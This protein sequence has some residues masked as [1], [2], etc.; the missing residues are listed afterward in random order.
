MIIK[1]IDY[2]KDKIS[3]KIKL[4]VYGIITVSFIINIIF[5][6]SLYNSMLNNESLANSVQVA[7]KDFT[8]ITEEN[9]F[10][11]DTI[12]EL[13]SDLNTTISH[14]VMLDNEKKATDQALESMAQFTSKEIEEIYNELQK[15]EDE[16]MAK[17]EP[18][19][20]LIEDLE[21]AL[22]TYKN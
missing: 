2:L 9:S 4:I 16:I 12:E 11:N 21:F 13:T 22:E 17:E 20:K 19:N 3:N 6:V 18:L 5:G 15:R 10:L 1:I 14:I 7:I 8:N